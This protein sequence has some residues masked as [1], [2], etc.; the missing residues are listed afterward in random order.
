MGGVGPGAAYVSGCIG[1][2]P[3]APLRR[4]LL[5]TED[6]IDDASPSA[7]ALLSDRLPGG[8]RPAAAATAAAVGYA[9]EMD[10]SSV[11][12]L[13]P[14]PDGWPSTGTLMGVQGVEL[15]TGAAGLPVVVGGGDGSEPKRVRR[16]PL[17]R[18][19]AAAIVT[20]AESGGKS[21]SVGA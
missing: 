20:A 4:L 18:V 5:P 15:V 11:T 8:A 2:E 16:R 12:E 17:P 21:A 1:D 13:T 9:C 19:P 6:D 10:A 7:D 14:V 3:K